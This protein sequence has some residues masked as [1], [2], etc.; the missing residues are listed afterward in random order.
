MSQNSQFSFNRPYK[1]FGFN[2]QIPERTMQQAE[3]T[4]GN[5]IKSP[6][7][8][9]FSFLEENESVFNGDVAY[10]INKINA[11]NFTIGSAMR[12]ENEKVNGTTPKLDMH[13]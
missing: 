3:Q 10:E 12:I 8:P 7:E 6:A 2:I 4:L 1:P 9:L 11:Q 13:F 5:L